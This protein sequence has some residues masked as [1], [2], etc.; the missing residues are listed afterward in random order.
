MLSVVLVMYAG[1]ALFF[2]VRLRRAFRVQTMHRLLSEAQTLDEL[3]SVSVCIPARNET[4]AM[5][6]CLES[7]IASRYPKMEIIVFDDESHDNTSYLIKS[8][9]HA[10]VRF[11][12]GSSL[13]DGWLGKNHAYQTL[14]HEA[15]GSYV[16]FMD[17]DTKIDPDTIGQLVSY[18]YQN[19]LLMLSVVPLRLDGWRSSVL[20]STLRYFWELVLHTKDRPSAASAAWMVHRQTMLNDLG[21]FAS[22][23]E[24]VQPEAAVAR[25]LALQDAYRLLVSTRLLGVHFEKK[26]RSQCETAR[27][28]L[29]PRLNVGFGGV[30]LAVAVY[31]ILIAGLVAPIVAIIAGWREIFV[32]FMV[33][34][35]AL[36]ILYGWYTHR[37]WSNKGWLGFF[38]WPIIILQDALLFG[39]S[40]AG[41]ARGTITWKGRPVRRQA[42]VSVET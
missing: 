5:T 2:F 11:V 19:K 18:V 41:Y 26:W 22:H 9:A 33:V 14:L 37:M 10:G 4:N 36:M 15:S 38:V 23:A 7:V 24:A 29:L 20:F 28:I 35:S 27:R 40:I 8:F 39:A 17:V 3:P 32:S 25:E 21:G 31:V 34:T 13:P 16:L 1:V 30:W 12:A 6:Q 42:P